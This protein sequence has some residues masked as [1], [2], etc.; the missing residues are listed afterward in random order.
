MNKQNWHDPRY[1]DPRWLNF[2][3]QLKQKRGWKCEKCGYVGGNLR[4]HHLA[5]SANKSRDPWDYHERH[6]IVIC[7]NCHNKA[8][9]IQTIPDDECMSDGKNVGDIILAKCKTTRNQFKYHL[10]STLTTKQAET[11]C[12]VVSDL[13]NIVKYRVTPSSA[14]RFI[15]E[16]IDKHYLH[17]ADWIMKYDA[18]RG[19]IGTI[20]RSVF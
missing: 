17:D 7:E 8:H 19:F 20:E 1:D 2:S 11:L 14:V 4:A 18:E 10:G 16:I 3:S 12:R 15:M 6:L 13:E 5:Y 9:N